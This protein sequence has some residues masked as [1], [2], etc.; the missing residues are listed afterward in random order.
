MYCS[1][2]SRSSFTSFFSLSI[3]SPTSAHPIL[4]ITIA[5]TPKTITIFLML[6]PPFLSVFLFVFCSLL[7]ANFYYP[8]TFFSCS[9]L[10][11][12]LLL[13][14]FQFNLYFYLSLFLLPTVFQFHEWRAG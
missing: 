13:I 7:S 8:S 12:F 10:I 9:F 1:D 5:K 14:P 3:L 4:I 6:I 2:A 11:C